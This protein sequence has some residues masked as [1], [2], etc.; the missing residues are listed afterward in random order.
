MSPLNDGEFMALLSDASCP[1]FVTMTRA[2]M[3]YRSQVL[4]YATSRP[5][6]VGA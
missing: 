5:V 4:R 6:E 2:S 1:G 3:T